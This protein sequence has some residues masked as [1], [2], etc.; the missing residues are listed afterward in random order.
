MHSLNI[1]YSIA[2][3]FLVLI[4][5]SVLNLLKEHFIFQL[6]GIAFLFMFIIVKISILFKADS[7]ILLV[8]LYY[9]ILPVL[10]AIGAC[11]VA[12]SLGFWIFPP[13]RK[14]LKTKK[15]L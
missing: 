11:L 1:S 3:F 6:T 2:V 9:T 13:I 12:M 5:A 8:D 4:S 7:N 14:N 15:G 10:S